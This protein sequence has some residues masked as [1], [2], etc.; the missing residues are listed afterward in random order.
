MRGS[1][2]G[3]GDFV[4]AQASSGKWYEAV[5]THLSKETK[6]NILDGSKWNYALW[7]TISGTDK[8]C[9]MN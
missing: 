2:L 4:G 1:M 6:E 9:K 8:D 3:V 7:R 5:I